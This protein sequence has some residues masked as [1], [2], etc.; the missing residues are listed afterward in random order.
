MLKTF[1]INIDVRLKE[2]YVVFS[3]VDGL[4]LYYRE[5]DKGNFISFYNI[6]IR[7]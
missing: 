4:N 1:L 2:I 3:W 5:P 6:N 7:S